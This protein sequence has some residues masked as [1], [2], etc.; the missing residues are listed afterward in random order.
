MKYDAVNYSL[1]RDT[2]LD[3]EQGGFI[4]RLD[5]R[6]LSINSAQKQILKKTLESVRKNL[7]W[8]YLDEYVK[9]VLAALE[10]GNMIDLV[11]AL[12]SSPTLQ[13]FL[14]SDPEFSR[15]WHWLYVGKNVPEVLRFWIGNCKSLSVMSKILLEEANRR[16][17][18]SIRKIEIIQ[19]D[20][21]HVYLKITTPKWVLEY[22]PTSIFYLT[23]KK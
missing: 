9:G 1:F 7:Q 22:D 21:F 4:D 5:Q 18:L 17:N 19:N 23:D 11:E 16:Y 3:T 15:A 12:I 8:D 2:P 13:R 20:E 10:G 14:L 6:S